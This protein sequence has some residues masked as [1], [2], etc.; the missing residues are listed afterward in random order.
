MRRDDEG[1]V[2]SEGKGLAP[3]LEDVPVN[4]L[5][6]A[7]REDILPYFKAEVLKAQVKIRKQLMKFETIHYKVEP[8]VVAC[9][10]YSNLVNNFYAM[11]KF[12][13]YQMP[14]LIKWY[15]LPALTYA[16]TFIIFP[17]LLPRA[18]G[19]LLNDTVGRV[20]VRW[21][22]S[23]PTPLAGTPLS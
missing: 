5:K 18:A 17:V 6:L 16:Y 20:G 23:L 15:L 11:N 1:G 13:T 19:V 10:M 14:H 7:P 3:R 4:E 22:V 9:N 21:R 2:D 8:M 12:K